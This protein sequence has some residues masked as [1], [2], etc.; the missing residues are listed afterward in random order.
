M[1]QLTVKDLAKQYGVSARDIVRELNEQGIETGDSVNAV[2]PEDMQELITDY[3]A[4]LYD[5][6]EIHRI[7]GGKDKRSKNSKGGKGGKE[8]NMQ[9]DNAPKAAA[10]AAAAVQN[11]GSITLPSPVIVK[12]L[13]EALGKKPN[14]LITDLIKLGELAGI[15]QPKNCAKITASNLSSAQLPKPLQPKLPKKRRNRTIRHS[16]KNVLPW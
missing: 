9:H 10:A 12:T 8:K 11:G 13:A 14:E 2:I 5:S 6:E 7:P 4:D 3:F 15:N 1:S 16:L